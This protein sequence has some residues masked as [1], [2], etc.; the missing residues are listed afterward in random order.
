MIL[1]KHFTNKINFLFFN[2]L[3]YPIHIWPFFTIVKTLLL[4]V[5]HFTIGTGHKQSMQNFYLLIGLISLLLRP[6]CADGDGLHTIRNEVVQLLFRYFI[7]V[8]VNIKN[9][10]YRG[11]GMIASYCNQQS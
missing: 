8:Q 3:L 7:T 4:A 5:R 10:S 6:R 2:L 11:F 1:R 9:F